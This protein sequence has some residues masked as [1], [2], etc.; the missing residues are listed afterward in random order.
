MK[1]KTS[2]NSTGTASPVNP[3]EDMDDIPRNPSMSF[4]LSEDQIVEF[5]QKAEKG[6]AEPAFRLY[7]YFSFLVVDLEKGRYWLEI[8]AKNGHNIA[9]YSMAT[10]LCSEKRF[11]E[12]LFWAKMAKLNG[13]KEA[14]HLIDR[15][16]ADTYNICEDSSDDLEK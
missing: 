14:D 6:D 1:D 12:A 2:I 7:L 5:S 11:K 9:Q 15:I 4:Y 8:S 13:M 10:F 3:A 16:C